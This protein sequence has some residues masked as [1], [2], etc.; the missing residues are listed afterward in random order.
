[1][2]LALVLGGR[3]VYGLL[4]TGCD[5]SVVSRRVIPNETLKPTAQKLYAANETEIALIGEVELTLLLTDYEVTEAVVVSDEVDDLILG[6]AWLERHRCR[7]SFAQNLIEIDGKVARLISRPRQ[8]AEKN[9]C[10]REYRSSSRPCHQRAR[11]IGFI[12]APP[13]VRRLGRG[14]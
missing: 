7:W 8:C 1:M 2:Y 11:D 12:V 14:T 6:I 3:R 9:L 5:T 10:R 4:D 13:D